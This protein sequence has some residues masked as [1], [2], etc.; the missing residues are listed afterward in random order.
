MGNDEE[1]DRLQV[2]VSDMMTMLHDLANGFSWR[3]LHKTL[4]A[5]ATE[6]KALG[7]DP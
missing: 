6:A 3:E 5:V 7:I 1:I 2:L 4:D